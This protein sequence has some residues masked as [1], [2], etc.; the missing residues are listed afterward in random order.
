MLS[1]GIIQRDFSVKSGDIYSNGYNLNISG[2][3]VQGTTLP[4]FFPCYFLSELKTVKS[5]ARP[6]TLILLTWRIW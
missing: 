6:V 5:F 1:L 2:K 3:L 4:Y